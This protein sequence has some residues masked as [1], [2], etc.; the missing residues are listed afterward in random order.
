MARERMSAAEQIRVFG[1]GRW[2][3]VREITPQ[4]S[5]FRSWAH[6]GW[7]VAAARLHR[8]LGRLIRGD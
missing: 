1:F 7:V 3:R 5:P 4:G 6:R 2:M 8:W